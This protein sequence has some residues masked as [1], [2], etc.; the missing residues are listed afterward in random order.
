MD[1][2]LAFKYVFKDE[3][4]I[5]KLAIVALWGLIPGVGVLVLGGWGL[6]VGKMVID[7]HAE[8]TLPKV[9][10]GADLRLGILASLI[11]LI[12][13]L[14]AVIFITTAY[15]LVKFGFYFEGIAREI[16]FVIGGLFGLV[17]LLLWIL[18][19]LIAT[20][21]FANFLAKDSFG[22]AFNLRELIGL[23]KNSF[24]SW[25]MVILGQILAMMIIAPLGLLL[26]GIGILFTTAYAGVLYAHLLGQAY[27]QSVAA[28]GDRSAV[29]S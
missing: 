10:F 7:G 18:W 28:G 23:L 16:L 22:A 24:I 27:Q 14:P 4:W 2:V 26:F 5:K 1:F 8:N 3:A 21:A 17:G 20:P 15:N 13:A 12:Y 11:D 25:L 9:E 29:E 6:K 19:F